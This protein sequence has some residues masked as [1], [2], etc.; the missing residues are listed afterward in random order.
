M[1]GALST[2]EA[3]DVRVRGGIDPE[4]VE[5]ATAMVDAVLTSHSSTVDRVRIRL[6]GS[7]CGRGPLL[8]QVNMWLHDNPARIQV[9]GA[10]TSAALTA[11]RDRLYRQLHRLHGGGANNRPWPD[12][13]RRPLGVPGPGRVTRLKSVRLQVCSPY[14]AAVVMNAMDYDAYLFTDSGTGEDAVVYRAGHTGTRLA[15]QRSMHPPTTGPAGLTVN[16]HRI[17]TLTFDQAST[18][19]IDG[20]LPYLFHTD[21]D[22][23]RGALLY[24]RY[25]GHLSLVRPG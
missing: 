8:V 6:S 22:T 3:I 13:Q 9:A 12:P 2:G 5:A 20:W 25:D 1:H 18:R 19:L 24:R 10:D 4:V 17:D 11:G 16:S 23:G 15:R 7:T 14:Q 21:H